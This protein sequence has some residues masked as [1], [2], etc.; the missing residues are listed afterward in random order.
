LMNG[1]LTGTLSV[2][3]RNEYGRL[4]GIEKICDTMERKNGQLPTGEYRVVIGKCSRFARQMIFLEPIRD[5]SSSSSSLPLP[6]TCKRCRMERKSHEFG[7]LEQLYALPCPMMQPGNGPFRLRQGGILIGEAHAPGFV[8][9]SQERFLQ[10][11]DRVSKM[12]RR[13]GEVVIKIE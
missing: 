9:K 5:D 11:F 10:L 12:L 8:L 7:C 4:S 2:E 6:E 1:A 3:H 13:G